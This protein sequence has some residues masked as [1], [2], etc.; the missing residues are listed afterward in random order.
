MATDPRRSL[1]LALGRE[2]QR[3]PIASAVNY[4]QPYRVLV[5]G[6]A[7]SIGQNVCDTLARGGVRVAPT[8]REQCDVTNHTHTWTAFHEHE[9]HAIIHLA[10]AKHAPDGEADPDDAMRVNAIGTRNVLAA[11]RTVGARVVTASTCKACDP[12]TAYGASKLIAER[13][14]LNAGQ[15]VARFYN[16]VESCGNV[17][18]LWEGVTGPIPVTT[19]SRFLISLDEATALIILALVQP[20]GRYTVEPGERQY[21]RDVARRLYPQR[22]LR[23]LETRRG[24]REHEPRMAHCEASHTLPNGL[25]QITSPHDPA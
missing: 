16:V 10:G 17:F 23:H 5:T 15:R 12:E 8:D 14:T 19:C 7:G 2:P 3:L 24:D 11:A 22:Q 20:S 25:V 13:L 21:M 4:L 9:P 6:A 1:R 18:R